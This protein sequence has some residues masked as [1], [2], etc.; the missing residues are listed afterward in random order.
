M[1]RAVASIDNGPNVKQAVQ[2]LIGAD[3]VVVASHINPDGDTLG[4]V[5]AVTHA[6]LA[7]GKQV[8]AISTDGVPDTLAWMPGAD[9]I[10]TTTVGTD[11]DLA[12]VCDAGALSRVGQGPL[13]AIEAAHRVIDIDHH[14][15]DGPF[16]DIQILD[17]TAA[18]T[19][20]LV[21]DLLTALSA[22]AGRDLVSTDVA[23]CLMTGLITD[24]GSFRFLNVTPRTFLLA[25]ELQRR[26]AHPA[27]IAELVFENRS[28]ASLKLLGRA[29]EALQT[30]QDGTVAWTHVTSADMEAVG[31]SDADTEGIV[32]HVRSVSGA[33]IGVL[34][35][36]IP[37]KKI[38]ISLRAREGA[39]VN[40]IAHVFGG[41]GHRLAAG[42]SVD[43]PLEQ[44]ESLVIA[45]CVR[46][47]QK[48]SEAAGDRSDL[49]NG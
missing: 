44:A 13:A 41:G 37:G 25:A 49:A 34:F 17:A 3:R 31:A 7:L 11:Y 46:Q 26:G 27:D 29:L 33:M 42:C 48:P 8:T 21:F 39:D 30:T 9:L 15:A 23:V 28:L 19:A 36:E 10:Q 2:A 5:L 32:G 45:E 6:L 20:E 16:G 38:R 12:V 40:R 18:A 22:E 47:N 35:R 24:T 43:P 4:C 1:S 14:I